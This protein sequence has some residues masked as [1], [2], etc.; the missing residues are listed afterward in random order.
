MLGR[1]ELEQQCVKSN[2]DGNITPLHRADDGN[3]DRH[4]RLH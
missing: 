4:L 3:N 2:S 1:R